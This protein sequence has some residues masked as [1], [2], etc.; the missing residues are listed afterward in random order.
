MR[1]IQLGLVLVFGV[2]IY[3]CVVGLFILVCNAPP[4]VIVLCRLSPVR[5]QFALI[6]VRLR[7]VGTVQAWV[8][9]GRGFGLSACAL[10][11][12]FALLNLPNAHNIFYTIS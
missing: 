3:W 4:L 10:P 2:R 1:L 11:P 9:W 6:A 5:L 8:R 7:G 12:C